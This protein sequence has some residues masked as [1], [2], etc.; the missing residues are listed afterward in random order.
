MNHPSVYKGT[1][2]SAVALASSVLGLSYITQSRANPITKEVT[3]S[4]REIPTLSELSD[5]DINQAPIQSLGEQETSEPKYTQ[6]QL[7]CAEAMGVDPSEC[8]QEGELIRHKNH[9][10]Q[11]RSDGEVTPQQDCAN[12]LGVPLDN[13]NEHGVYIARTEGVLKK[14][15]DRFHKPKEALTPYDL[16]TIS[17]IGF[18]G[19][20]SLGD[21]DFD[22][23]TRIHSINIEWSELTTLPVT[24]GNL[25]SLQTFRVTNNQIRVL[26]SELIHNS[27]LVNLEILNLNYNKLREIPVEFLELSRLRHLF[28]GNNDITKLPEGIG[29]IERLSFLGINNNPLVISLELYQSL[30]NKPKGVNLEFRDISSDITRYPLV[31][32]NGTHA[33]LSEVITPF[34]DISMSTN[35]IELINPQN[36]TFKNIHPNNLTT[37]QEIFLCTYL[38]D[39]LNQDTE[40]AL[41]LLPICDKPTT[42]PPTST[43]ETTSSTQFKSGNDDSVV[44]IGVMFSLVAL[45]VITGFGVGLGILLKKRWDQQK[46]LELK[47]VL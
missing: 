35:T 20:T 44:G 27:S 22:G 11:K 10:S 1:L 3:P 33:S 45:M 47:P 25:E 40:S 4:I 2:S 36:A 13:C 29:N 17:H 43:S 39:A 21:H 6:K 28:L 23:F 7:Q 34:Y 24:L 5:S 12:R 26:P 46:L 8:T 41:E 19:L 16:S 18:N 32:L 14:L 9:T 30:M 42:E 15:T 37:N 31:D 38:I